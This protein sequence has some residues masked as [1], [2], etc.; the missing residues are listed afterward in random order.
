M[1]K[2]FPARRLAATAVAG[3]F[4][5]FAAS[6]NVVRLSREMALEDFRD[7]GIQP[8]MVELA[9]G[10]M[11]VFAGGEGPAVLL[12]HG[13]GV[14]ALETWKRQVPALSP[15]HRVI[16]VD[17]FWFGES[18][19]RDPAGVSGAPEQADA[20]A[21]LLDTLGVP[22]AAVVGVSFGGLVALELALRHPEKVV[23]LILVDAAG[24]APTPAERA[25]IARNFGGVTDLTHV[26]IP[27]DI[28][29]LR[30]FLERVY[31]HPPF[32]PNFALQQVLEE[33]F[34]K[35]RPAKAR[36]CRVILDGGLHPAEDFAAIR[37]P[38][39]L[40]WG[41]H[42]PLVL[43]SMGRR[44]EQAI[45]GARL[46]VFEESGHLPM[47]EEPERFNRVMREFL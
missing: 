41:R 29:E 30:R 8:A 10:R 2:S 38:T 35:H 24:L 20:L 9:A 26:L 23:R 32:I 22:H 42:D 31:H 13:F 21:E 1:R 47:I 39:L 12:V 7:H 17:L 28:Y 19:P 5:F 45:P 4:L 37:A 36:I 46:S 16:A 6:C 18:V 27:A 11:R 44:L 40:V 15:G 33:E 25:E 43:L 3:L 34:W 14:G